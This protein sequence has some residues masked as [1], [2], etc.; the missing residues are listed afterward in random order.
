MS[1]V[2]AANLQSTGS[3]APAFKNSSGTEIGQLAKAWGLI[4]SDGTIS[5]DF[6]VSSVTLNSTGKYTISFSTALSS[7][8]YAV[9]AT[10]NKEL[11]GV[12]QEQNIAYFNASTSGFSLNQNNAAAFESNGFAFVVHGA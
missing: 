10:V 2:K 4:Q 12:S 3:G 11:T 9:N 8:N 1:T 7:A 5:D 6:N